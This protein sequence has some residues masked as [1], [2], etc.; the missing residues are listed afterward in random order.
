MYAIAK[1]VYLVQKKFFTCIIN[2]NKAQLNFCEI[3]LLS[4]VKITDKLNR[5]PV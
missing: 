5:Y 2:Y 4:P 1:N 3:Y